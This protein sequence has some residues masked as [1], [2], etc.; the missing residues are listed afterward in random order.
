[1]GLRTLRYTYV[2]H[3]GGDRELY[4]MQKDPHQIDNIHGRADDALLDSLRSRLDDLKDCAG[5]RCREAEG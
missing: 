5:A 4:G 3:E 2:E 1:V